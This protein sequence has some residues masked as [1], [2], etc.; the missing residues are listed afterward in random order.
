MQLAA[1][2][3][4]RNKVLFHC[5]FERK[6][7]IVHSYSIFSYVGYTFGN[8]VLRRRVSGAVK[9]NFRP[10]IRRYTSPNENFEYSYPLISIKSL[11]YGLYGF[12]WV[13]SPL[14]YDPHC[15]FKLCQ[16][17]ILTPLYVDVARELFTQPTFSI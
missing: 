6:M 10:Y 7:L 11:Y 13:P 9:L 1:A 4:R 15:T 5:L 14:N 12:F 3:R 2:G 16:L 8:H 17:K